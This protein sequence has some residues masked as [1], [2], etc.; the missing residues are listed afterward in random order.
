[1]TLRRQ[2][3]HFKD[4]NSQWR[5]L[6]ARLRPVRSHSSKLC[7]ALKFVSALSNNMQHRRNL[8]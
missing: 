3:S 1:M 5:R 2:V 6:K 8:Q 7:S 4:T